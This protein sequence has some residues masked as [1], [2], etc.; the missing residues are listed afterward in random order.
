MTWG[1]L[2]PRRELSGTLSLY[3]WLQ[4]RLMKGDTALLPDR[5]AWTLVSPP[6]PL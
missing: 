4:A 5:G 6:C 1:L 2:S 3:T